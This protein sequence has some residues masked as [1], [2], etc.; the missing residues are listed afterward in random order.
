[1]IAEKSA[2]EGVLSQLGDFMCNSAVKI[3]V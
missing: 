3:E 1:L 2:S